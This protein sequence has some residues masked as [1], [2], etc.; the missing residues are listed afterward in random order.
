MGLSLLTTSCTLLPISYQKEDSGEL[1]A[2]KHR[3]AC[4]KHDGQ[5]WQVLYYTQVPRE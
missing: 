5:A 3:S 1:I 2:S 4:F